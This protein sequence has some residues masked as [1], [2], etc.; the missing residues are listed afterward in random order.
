[1]GSSCAHVEWMGSKVKTS[2]FTMAAP[3]SN[4]CFTFCISHPYSHLQ[5]WCYF[6]KPLNQVNLVH[7]AAGLAHGRAWICPLAPFLLLFLE[8]MSLVLPAPGQV[9]HPSEEGTPFLLDY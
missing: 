4:F 5:S 6:T 8:G 1:M 7:K 3:T 2:H 9:W